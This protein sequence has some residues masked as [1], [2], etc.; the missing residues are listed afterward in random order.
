MS[1]FNSQA[2]PFGPP[3]P[4][5]YP[6]AQQQQMPQYG[7]QPG[8]YAPQQQGGYGQQPPPPGQRKYS[9]YL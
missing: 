3:Q 8:G 2:Q 1:N 9:N 7:Y 4:G 5:F 6:P